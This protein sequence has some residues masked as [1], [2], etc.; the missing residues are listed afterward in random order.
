MVPA[1]FL[2][3]SSH[4][5]NSSEKHGKWIKS[6][7][8][9]PFWQKLFFLVGSWRFSGSWWFFDS[10]F[11]VFEIAFLKKLSLLV[12]FKKPYF[13]N[14]EKTRLWKIINRLTKNHQLPKTN[15]CRKST[16]FHFQ[17][18][19]NLNYVIYIFDIQ[20]DRLGTEDIITNITFNFSLCFLTLFLTYD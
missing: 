9:V 4:V 12:V 15:F 11:E 10:L 2:I 13:E 8:F 6:W 5:P 16:N 3:R 1:M 19:S 17:P 14:H 20:R 18:L 7:K